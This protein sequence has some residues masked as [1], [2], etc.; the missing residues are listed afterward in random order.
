ML[1]DLFDFGSSAPKDLTFTQK[2]GL[3]FALSYWEVGRLG[4]WTVKPQIHEKGFGPSSIHSTPRG[5]G[6]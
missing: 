6:D 2:R 5:L 4:R 3:A 1:S